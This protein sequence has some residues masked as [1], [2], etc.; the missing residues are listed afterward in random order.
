MAEIEIPHGEGKPGEKRVGILIAIIAVLLAVVGALGH[1]AANEM[2]VDEVKASNAFS[3]Y[4]AKRQ[5]EYLNDIELRRIDIELAGN[6]TPAQG[7]ALRHLASDLRKKNDEYRK[8]GEHIQAEARQLGLDARIASARNDGFDHAEIL[9]QVAIVLCS[10]T[11]LTESRVFL[12]IGL[13]VAVAGI[14]AGGLAF[15]RKAGPVAAE[16]P[17][18]N[19]S[20]ARPSSH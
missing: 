20:P 19:A 7:D 8:E 3:W 15:N 13:A 5:R 4:Q 12:R 16:T 2:I 11:L 10:L 1:D 9:L 6:P 14:V 17:P 18:A